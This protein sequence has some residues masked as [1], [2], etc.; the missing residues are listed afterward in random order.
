MTAEQPSSP[1]HGDAEALLRPSAWLMG[2]RRCVRYQQTNS[3]LTSRL[4]F[5]HRVS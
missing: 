1:R 2:G 5:V 4:H 3:Q